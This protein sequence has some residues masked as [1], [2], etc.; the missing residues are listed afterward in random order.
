MIVAKAANFLNDE[1]KEE[2][3]QKVREREKRR[4]K[5]FS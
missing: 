4:R 2:G 1:W 3:G 5:G